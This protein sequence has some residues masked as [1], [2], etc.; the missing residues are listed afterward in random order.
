MNDAIVTTSNTQ[1]MLELHD[2]NSSQ[3]NVDCDEQYSVDVLLSA[4]GSGDA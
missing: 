4:P 2:A 1:A 3:R